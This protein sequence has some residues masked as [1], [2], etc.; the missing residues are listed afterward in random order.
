MSITIS[1]TPSNEAS[2]GELN[3]FL[4]SRSY[5]VGCVACVSRAAWRAAALKPRC[6]YHS[7]HVFAASCRLSPMSPSPLPWLV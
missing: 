5:I 6:P 7:C 2:L 1:F 4:Q 3:V